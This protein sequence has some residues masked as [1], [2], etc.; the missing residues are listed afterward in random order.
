MCVSGQTPLLRQR[1]MRRVVVL[2]RVFP[3]CTSCS[4][5]CCTM[6]RRHRISLRPPLEVGGWAIVPFSDAAD[7][8]RDVERIVVVRAIA[9][10]SVHRAFVAGGE[11]GRLEN[12]LV[13]GGVTR[14]A[15]AVSLTE[16]LSVPDAM[17]RASAPVDCIVLGTV[18][19]MWNGC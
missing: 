7:R 12:R 1:V 4:A 5:D 8:L 19:G 3:V 18:V 10:L 17:T 2:K 6:L 14:C 15:S 13:S 9:V 16:S 11:Q